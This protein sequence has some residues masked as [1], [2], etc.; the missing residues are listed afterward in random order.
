M[1]HSVR[2]QEQTFV[3]EFTGIFFILGAVN[4]NR[5]FQ[6]VFLEHF[7]GGVLLLLLNATTISTR[8]S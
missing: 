5:V 7:F 4:I 3:F 8:K 6:G 2:E 1:W